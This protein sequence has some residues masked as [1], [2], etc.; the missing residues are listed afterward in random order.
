VES[1]R[2]EEI[3]AR[4]S[5]VMRLRVG[6]RVIRVTPEH[7]FYAEDRGR[8]AARFLEVGDRLHTLECVKMRVEELGEADEVVP[9]YDFRVADFQTYF[10]GTPAGGFRLDA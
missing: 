7:A 4:V 10:V 5:P 1:K 3:F 6:G 2:V 8:L 9:V